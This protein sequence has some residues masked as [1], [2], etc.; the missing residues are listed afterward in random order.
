M[1]RSTSIKLDSWKPVKLLARQSVDDKILSISC[2]LKGDVVAALTNH[3][4]VFLL[5]ENYWIT[6]P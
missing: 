2:D 4:L 5:I 1:L 3:Q 6:Y